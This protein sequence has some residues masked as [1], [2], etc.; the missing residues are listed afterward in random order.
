M[1]SLVPGL[2]LEIKGGVYGSVC[3]QSRDLRESLPFFRVVKI[4]GGNLCPLLSFGRETDGQLE[5]LIM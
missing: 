3:N 4:R 2:G 1:E 5:E